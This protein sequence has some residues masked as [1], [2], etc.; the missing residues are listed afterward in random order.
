MGVENL[1]NDVL[2]EGFNFYKKRYVAFILGA[3]I[4][5]V[6]SIFIITAP[7]LFF[8]IYFMALKLLRGEEVEIKDVFKG[9]D[10]FIVSWVM[11]ILGGLAV[12]VGLIFLV[13]PG[14]LLL[15]LFQ[16]AVPIAISEN[17][18]A[19]DSLKKSARIA[20]D[21]LSFSVILLIILAVINSLGSGIAFGWLIAYPYTVIC[22]CIATQK[23]TE[24]KKG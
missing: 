12:I 16:F 6:S 17:I 18:G 14:L 24:G 19:I 8:G 11:L 2:R 5:A 4:A 23:L 7:P 15:I 20:W 10:Y 3:L 22:I 13:I 9:F 1:L 21:N